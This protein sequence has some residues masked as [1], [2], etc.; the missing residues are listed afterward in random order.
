MENALQALNQSKTIVMS[1]HNNLLSTAKFKEEMN[2]CL[3]E[4]KESDASKIEAIPKTCLTTTDILI[5][6]KNPTD[7]HLA[8]SAPPNIMLSRTDNN[9]HTS[10]SYQRTP[11]QLLD[12]SI[13]YDGNQQCNTSTSSDQATNERNIN[14]PALKCT[15]NERIHSNETVI[16]NPVTNER[17]S[18]HIEQGNSSPISRRNTKNFHHVEPFHHAYHVGKVLGKGGFGVV[19]E[20]TRIR[21]GLQVALKHILKAKITDFG[22]VRD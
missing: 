5:N 2:S 3:P 19:Y 9:V 18:R 10:E 15:E 6:I 11:D 16:P 8:K 17:M 13:A 4:C 1:L 14:T 21:D 12:K 20:G 22:Q 7:T